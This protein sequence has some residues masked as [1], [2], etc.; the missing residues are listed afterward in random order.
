MRGILKL[1]A[2]KRST[3]GMAQALPELPMAETVLVRLAQILRTSLHAYL[4]PMFRRVGFNENSFHVLC[5][6]LSSENGQASPSELAELVGTS[7]ANMT[8]ILD[9]MDADQ[10]ITRTVESLDARRQVIEITSTGRA[11]AIH[12]VPG[13]KDAL[14]AAFSGLNEQEMETLTTLMQKA[15]LS[16]DTANLPG[17]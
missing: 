1:A 12:A 9:Q 7:K 14:R 10:L 17:L 5:L 8:R 11:Q 2:V 13:F 6:L 3:P 16:L 15:I 4:D